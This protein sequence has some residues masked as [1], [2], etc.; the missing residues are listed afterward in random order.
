MNHQCETTTH[1]ESDNEAFDLRMSEQTKNPRI[2]IEMVHSRIG[3][4]VL[5]NI[6]IWAVLPKVCLNCSKMHFDGRRSW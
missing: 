6:S 4:R 5:E 2:L 1:Q 3:G